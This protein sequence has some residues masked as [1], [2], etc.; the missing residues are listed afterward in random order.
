M[1]A[2][3]Y[4]REVNSGS[5][6]QAT[7]L[8]AEALSVLQLSPDQATQLAGMSTQLARLKREIR[9]VDKCLAGL[10][11]RSRYQLSGAGAW[12]CVWLWLCVCARAC[13]CV[14]GCAPLPGSPR[15][16]RCVWCWGRRR[17]PRSA[18]DEVR[19]ARVQ[20][21]TVQGCVD[22]RTPPEVPAV[23]HHAR[24]HHPPPAPAF[25]GA[26]RFAARWGL[27]ARHGRGSGVHAIV[28]CHRSMPS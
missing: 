28:V 26:H 20:C 25:H 15:L 9:K 5:S 18:M 23:E 19:R 6:R 10:I 4:A 12:R 24:S 16:T 14:A 11:A 2:A 7:P 27:R 1:Q 21:A 13:A 17:R 22:A 8:V 3:M